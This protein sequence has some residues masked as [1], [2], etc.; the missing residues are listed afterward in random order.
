RELSKSAPTQANQSFRN[1]RALLNWAREKN[2][3]SDGTYPILP[4]NPVSQMFKQGGLAKWNPEK[5]RAT[6][7]PKDKIGA[8]WHLLMQHADP[9]RNITTTCTSADLIAF[10]LLTGTRVSEARQLTWQ[11]VN[12]DSKIPTYHL[13]ETKNHNPV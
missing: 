12:L 1:L 9:E 8:V 11:R 7:V 2:A 5:A 4:V 13:A 6:R 10:M 3:A